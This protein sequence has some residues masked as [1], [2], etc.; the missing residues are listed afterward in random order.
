MLLRLA[1]SEGL[2]GHLAHGMQNLPVTLH[3]GLKVEHFGNLREKPLAGGD[4]GNCARSVF[5][6]CV[7]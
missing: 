5:D 7:M 3:L 4:A 6:L 2:I 1:I